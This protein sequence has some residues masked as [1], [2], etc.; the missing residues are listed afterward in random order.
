MV[1][2]EVRIADD[3]TKECQRLPE[4]PARLDGSG[5]GSGLIV[6]GVDF[7]P[8]DAVEVPSGPNRNPLGGWC[9]SCGF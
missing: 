2:D 1:F 9:E 4:Q 8:R 7:V 5:V 3:S 6:E